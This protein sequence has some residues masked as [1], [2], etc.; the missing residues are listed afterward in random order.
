MPEERDYFECYSRHILES[1]MH[2]KNY[3]A[4]TLETLT[5][6]LIQMVGFEKSGRRDKL[7]PMDPVVRALMM[8]PTTRVHKAGRKRKVP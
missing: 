4:T 2:R 6:A 8:D 3:T 1:I 7:N 5:E